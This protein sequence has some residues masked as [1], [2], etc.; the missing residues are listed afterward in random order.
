MADK[1]KLTEQQQKHLEG[2]LFLMGGPRRAGKTFLFA[3]VLLELAHER[4]GAWTSFSIAQG[5]FRE[6]QHVSDQIELIFK[7]NYDTEKYALA[8]SIN[9]GQIRVW[10][11]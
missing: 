3:W 8:M 5:S 4:D 9:T 11:K 10:E 1:L 7:A 2:A 6:F